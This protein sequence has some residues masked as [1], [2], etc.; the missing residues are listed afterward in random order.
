[1]HQKVN[2]AFHKIVSES[3]NYRASQTHACLGPL[4]LLDAPDFRVAI[5]T[6]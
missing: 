6:D 5:L 4:D 3:E 2:E 1:M